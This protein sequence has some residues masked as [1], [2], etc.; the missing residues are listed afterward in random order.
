MWKEPLRKA[1]IGLILLGP[2]TSGSLLLRR[3]WA[4]KEMDGIAWL[5]EELSPSRRTLFHVVMLVDCSPLP[6][7]LAWPCIAPSNHTVNYRQVMPF[8]IDINDSNWEVSCS[9]PGED[10]D[11]HECWGVGSVRLCER[12]VALRSYA[13]GLPRNLRLSTNHTASH[14]LVQ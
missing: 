5:A 4:F 1:W 13:F 3:P 10:M 2:G 9:N 12:C 11:C 7:H 14:S 8:H 6:P